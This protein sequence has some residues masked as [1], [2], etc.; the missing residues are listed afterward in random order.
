MKRVRLT[1]LAEF[2]LVEAQDFYAQ[3][4]EWVLDHF[5][6]CISAALDSLADFAGIHAVHYGHHRMGVPHFPFSVYYDIEG[7]DVIVKAILDDR[8]GPARIAAHFGPRFSE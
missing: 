3:S 4:G 1:A 6:E 7:E 2:D 5:M 8:F